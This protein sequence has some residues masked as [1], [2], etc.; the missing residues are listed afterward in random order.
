MTQLRQAE[1]TTAAYEKAKAET[2]SVTEHI[3]QLYANLVME[4]A[5]QPW[6]KIVSKQIDAALWTNNQEI[7]HAESALSHGTHLWST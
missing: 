2:A 4:K 6:T 5:G 3:F 1:K 7:K